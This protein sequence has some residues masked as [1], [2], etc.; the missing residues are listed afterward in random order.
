M[1][2]AF[3]ASCVLPSPLLAPSLH[4]D[5][6]R[7]SDKAHRESTLE[8]G[9]SS[10]LLTPDL[11]TKQPQ[12]LGWHIALI[13]LWSLILLFWEMGQVSQNQKPSVSLHS[14]LSDQIITDPAHEPGG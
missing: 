10:L 5:E 7:K 4:K 8:V 12:D 3:P 6:L 2:C 1:L 13:T 14:Q 9:S 11:T